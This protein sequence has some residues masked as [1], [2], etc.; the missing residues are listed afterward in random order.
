MPLIWDRMVKEHARPLKGSADFFVLGLRS[1]LKSR[2]FYLAD[3]LSFVTLL[4]EDLRALRK[5]TLTA[6][7]ARLV[8]APG[9]VG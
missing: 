7:E 3:N 5:R 8:I 2:D 4:A 9:T 1:L 6:E